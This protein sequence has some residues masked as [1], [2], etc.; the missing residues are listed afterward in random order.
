M[1]SK[2]KC[3]YTKESAKYNNKIYY[4]SKESGI[5]Q[6]GKPPDKESEILPAGWEHHISKSGDS[7]Y[8][9]IHHNITQWKKPNKEDNL[10]VPAGWEEMRSKNCKNV[11]YINSKRGITQ[12]EYPGIPSRGNV[13]NIIEAR[14]AIQARNDIGTDS[15]FKSLDEEFP[16]Y[17]VKDFKSAPSPDSSFKSLDEEFPYYGVK[18]F[19]TAS[20]RDSSFK[21]APSPDSSF[22]SAPSPDSSFKSLDDEFLYGLPKVPYYGASRAQQKADQIRFENRRFGQFTEDEHIRQYKNMGIPYP[23]GKRPDLSKRNLEKQ[24]KQNKRFIP[25][26]THSGYWDR[27]DI[28]FDKDNKID[29]Y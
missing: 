21:S 24:K 25:R 15:S 7:F 23:T 18:D 27:S 12:W 5:S 20:S 11:Y 6:W 28:Y 4:V 9:N 10:S 14:H 17:G 8:H 29:W 13:E 3:W 16:Y 1:N 26:Q 22:R 19:R 2:Q